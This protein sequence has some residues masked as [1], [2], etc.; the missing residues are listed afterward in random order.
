MDSGSTKVQTNRAVDAGSVEDRQ[1]FDD[2][3]RLQRLVPDVTALDPRADEPSCE[4]NVVQQGRHRAGD[5]G[6]QVA[7]TSVPRQVRMPCSVTTTGLPRASSGRSLS[8]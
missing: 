1:V 2:A 7:V 4:R 5:V 6:A 3:P 8:R